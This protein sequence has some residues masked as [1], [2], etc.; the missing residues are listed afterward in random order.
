[1]L[2]SCSFEKALEVLQSVRQLRRMLAM[3]LAASILMSTVAMATET[4]I[5]AKNGDEI[6]DNTV[7]DMLNVGNP[8][9]GNETPPF[10][11]M[12]GESLL[13]NKE[14]ELLLFSL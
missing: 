11:S 9:T 7:S 12:N 6:K 14:N 5:K 8:L 3:M 10:I 1:M 2:R 13:L 4:A